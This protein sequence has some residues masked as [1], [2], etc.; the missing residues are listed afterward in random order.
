VSTRGYRLALAAFLPLVLLLGAAP[1]NG[2]V[3]GMEAVSGT[4]VAAATDPVVV[5]AGDICG[6]GTDCGPTAALIAQIAPTRVLPLGDNAY[7]DG[8]IDQYNSY[9]QPNWGGSKS[10]TS[11]VPG[12]HDY[13]TTNGDGY[14]SYFGARAPAAYYSYN[15]GTWHLIALNGEIDVSAGSPQEAWLKAD[16]AAHPKACVLAYWHEPLHVG[17][18]ALLEFR[19]RPLLARPLRG[20]GRHCPQRPRPQLRALRAPEPERAG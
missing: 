2:R 12:N 19:L 7:N 9:Y 14:F 8:T 17:N 13:H 4:E 1:S 18:G 10:I 16:L 20:R 11:P 6:S 5:A 3:A 15:L